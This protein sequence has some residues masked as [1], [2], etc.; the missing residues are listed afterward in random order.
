MK[1]RAAIPQTAFRPLPT[2]VKHN[3]GKS[4]RLIST[5]VAPPDEETLRKLN[6]IAKSYPF[7][8]YYRERNNDPL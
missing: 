5:T 1:P 6:E 3:S 2:P 8:I 7:C 4:K